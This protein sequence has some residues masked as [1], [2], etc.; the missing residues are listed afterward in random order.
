ML[1]PVSSSSLSI[2]DALS[3]EKKADVLLANRDF[4]KS[5]EDYLKS[6][7]ILT[8]LLKHKYVYNTSEKVNI[9]L[10]LARIYSEVSNTKFLRVDL[11]LE[12]P[13]SKYLKIETANSTVRDYMQKLRE[14]IESDT[15]LQALNTLSTRINHLNTKIISENLQIE[16]EIVKIQSLTQE[17]TSFYNWVIEQKTPQQKN[18]GQ[19]S[20]QLIPQGMP[21]MPSQNQVNSSSTTSSQSSVKFPLL[22]NMLGEDAYQSLINQVKVLHGEIKNLKKRIKAINNTLVKN[23]KGVTGATIPENIPPIGSTG[24]VIQTQHLV[25]KT[26]LTAEQKTQLKTEQENDQT[27]IDNDKTEL[28]NIANNNCSQYYESEIQTHKRRKERYIKERN[29]HTSELAIAKE[30]ENN[31]LI[32]LKSF[33]PKKITTYLQEASDLDPLNPKILFYLCTLFVQQAE[34]LQEKSDKEQALADFYK[35][36]SKE[37]LNIAEKSHASGFANERYKESQLYKLYSW[38]AKALSVKYHEESQ[39]KLNQLPNLFLTS[40]ERRKNQNC[41]FYITLAMLH[42]NYPDVL[43]SILQESPLLEL[44]TIS[45]TSTTTEKKGTITGK[46]G[47]I[48]ESKEPDVILLLQEAIKIGKGSNSQSF[49]LPDAYYYLGLEY[50]NLYSENSKAENYQTLAVEYLTKAIILEPLFLSVS[51]DIKDFTPYTNNFYTGTDLPILYQEYNLGQISLQK[52]ST[53]N[54]SSSTAVS[55]QNQQ[56]MPPGPSGM[57]QEGNKS[58]VSQQTSNSS[59]GKSKQKAAQGQKTALPYSPA[60]AQIDIDVLNQILDTSL[61]KNPE[62]NSEIWFRMTLDYLVENDIPSA[63]AAS[64]NIK[65][66]ILYQFI[67]KEINQKIWGK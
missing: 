44:S 37:Q 3:L 59:S 66:P 60:M 45:N 19:P 58:G 40:I 39:W 26:G 12:K 35:N 23:S 30:W 17:E 67:K 4:Q 42:T 33:S 21:G 14:H 57:T 1:N 50:A 65:N 11:L 41:L 6:I 32:S 47:T 27:E 56:G 24:P 25:E 20:S 22:V 46:K 55:T 2:N 49:Y 28:V 29:N 15:N 9:Y 54:K 10:S 5:F 36:K 48:T 62:T 51:R 18:T 31:I 8:D 34:N 13:E 52:I 61:G 38:T 16:T 64:Y 7:N 43:T 63:L 53:T